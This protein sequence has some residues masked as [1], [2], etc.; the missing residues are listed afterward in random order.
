M[1]RFQARMS[2]A[3]GLIEYHPEREVKF[4]FEIQEENV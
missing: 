4:Y 3:Y 2:A 1:K